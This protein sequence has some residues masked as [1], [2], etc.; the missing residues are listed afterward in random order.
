MARSPLSSPRRNTPPV[1]AWQR[2]AAADAPRTVLMPASPAPAAGWSPA[3]EPFSA[4][5]SAYQPSGG[6]PFADPA[7]SETLR[8]QTQAI[9]AAFGRIEPTL[10][11]LAPRHYDED[12]P[13]VA[14]RELREIGI[15]ISPS[16]FAAHV[17]APLNMRFLHARC[18]IGTFCRFVRDGGARQ[19]TRQSDGEDAATL[20]RQWGFHAIDVSPCADGRLSGLMDHILRIPPS[21]IAF[22]EILCGRAVQ[23]DGRAAQLGECG[24]A[25]LA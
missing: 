24:A 9:D 16:L 6:H 19:P 17:M 11:R 8:R 1:A 14:V 2:L 22:R 12:F 23:P 4:P 21:V 7:I 10:L 25:P 5:R 18:V 20:I 15:E 13:Q 3:A